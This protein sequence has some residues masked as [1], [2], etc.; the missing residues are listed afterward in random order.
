MQKLATDTPAA[1]NEKWIRLPTKGR[2]P[3]TGFSRAGYYTLIAQGRIKSAN[4]REPGKLT[5]IRLVWLPSVLEY[6]ERHVE[7]KGQA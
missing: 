5:G 7:T 2:C 3:Y 1:S 4:V 6:I